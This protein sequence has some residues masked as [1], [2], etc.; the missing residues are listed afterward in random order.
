MK[1]IFMLAVAFAAVSMVACGGN[2]EKKAEGEQAEA[3]N[4]EVV[5]DKACCG[6]CEEG[7]CCGECDKAA[8]A[9]AEAEVVE[10]EVVETPEVVEE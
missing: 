2:K 8:E 9:E 4:V 3:A 6:A 1:K 10:A 5:E 7:E